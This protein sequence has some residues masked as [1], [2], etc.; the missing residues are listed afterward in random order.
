MIRVIRQAVP[1]LLG[2]L[3]LSPGPLKAAGGEAEP[4]YLFPIQVQADVPPQEVTYLTR[5]FNE[6][7]GA[8]FWLKPVTA[9][10]AAQEIGSAASRVSACAATACALPILKVAGV[11]RAVVILIE[12]GPRRKTYQMEAAIYSTSSGVQKRVSHLEEGG[13][14]ELKYALPGVLEKLFGAELAAHGGQV[15]SIVENET[16]T[17]TEVD[18]VIEEGDGRAEEG[19]DA[20]AIAKYEEAARQS[21]S[22]STPWVKIAQVRLRQGNAGAALTAAQKATSLNPR[23]ATAHLVQ[24][25]AHLRLKQYAQAEKSLTAALGIDSGLTKARF[26]LGQTYVALN[27]KAEAARAFAL[28]VKADPASAPARVNLGILYLDLG[29][30]PNAREHLREAVRL[31]PGL[32]SAYAPLARACESLGDLEGAISAYEHYLEADPSC[33]DCR[34]EIDRLNSMRDR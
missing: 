17:S 14:G 11:P 21:P 31:D 8:F 13:V 20:G 34:G 29:D 24:G 19:D 30:A 28:V 33:A 2:F 3:L 16:I 32:T 7:I 6:E 9:D 22:L 12:K 18:S 5:V 10:T 25:E 26:L 27:R 15:T 1:M 23:D 4:I